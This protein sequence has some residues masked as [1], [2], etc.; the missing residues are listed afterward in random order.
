MRLAGLALLLALVFTVPCHI[1]FA[2][3][4]PPG[5]YTSMT[6]EVREIASPQPLP[7]IPASRTL[8]WTNKGEDF[9]HVTQ[10]NG[11]AIARRYY[12]E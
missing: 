2:V 8:T 10:N 6:V 11:V 9:L 7:G 5:R 3:Q 4:M 12:K 1:V